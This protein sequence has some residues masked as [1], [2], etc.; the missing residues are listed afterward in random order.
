MSI[1]FDCAACGK[2]YKVAD[3][4]AGKRAKCKACGGVIQVPALDSGPVEVE[5]GEAEDASSPPPPPVKPPP[6]AAKAPASFQTA[7]SACPSCRAPLAPKA[8]LCV[9]CGF[10]LRKGAKIAGVADAQD[11][12]A[13][14]AD[15]AEEES[16]GEQSSAGAGN[17]K[18]WWAFWKK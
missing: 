9:A 16:T 11:D 10:D 8:V 15:A 7:E 12:D 14:T 17:E 18:K 4:M 5:P 3:A 13:E 6:V 1:E 2:H